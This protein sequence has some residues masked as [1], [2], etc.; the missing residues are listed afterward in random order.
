MLKRVSQEAYERKCKKN[1]GEDNGL[2][3]A[4]ETKKQLEVCIQNWT[5]SEEITASF[6][7]AKMTEN[8]TP[9]IKK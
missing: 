1:T 2:A 8:Y 6:T 7:T 3:K 5:D 9:L 4:R